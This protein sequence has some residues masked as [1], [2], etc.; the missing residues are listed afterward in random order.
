[1]FK[2]PHCVKLVDSKLLILLYYWKY[3]Y[4]SEKIL[5]D[6]SYIY[7]EHMLRLLV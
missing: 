4:K 1:M 3:A 7:L 6:D 2:I 5:L